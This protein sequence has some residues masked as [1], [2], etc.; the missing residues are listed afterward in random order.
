MQQD[1]ADWDYAG[2][3]LQTEGL[4]DLAGNN[5]GHGAEC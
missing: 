5:V 3:F 2:I 4:G 1:Y